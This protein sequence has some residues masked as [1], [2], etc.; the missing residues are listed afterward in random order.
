MKARVC[1]VAAIIAALPLLAPHAVR[2]DP[3]DLRLGLTVDPT[4][5]VHESFND[6]IHVPPIPAPLAELSA[7]SGRTE[8]AAFGLP[9][10][11]AIPYTDRIQSQT[12]LRLTILDTTLRYYLS[13]RVAVGIGETIYNQTTHYAIADYYP[14]TGERQYSR[15]IGTHLELLE[16]SPLRHG[17]LETSLRYAPTMLGTQVSTYESSGALTRYN[18]ERGQQV[19]ADVRYVRPLDERRDVILGIRYVNY[20]T[21]YVQPGHPLADRNAGVLPSFGYRWKVGR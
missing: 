13:D 12:A 8:L 20:T 15:V 16:I 14:N 18:P 1:V 3:L 10:T 6:T 19:D 4:I 9:P 7:R 21:G 17:R 11:V 5:G 2:A